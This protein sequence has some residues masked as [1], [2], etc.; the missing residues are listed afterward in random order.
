[1][2][3]WLLRLA[4]LAAAVSCR[5]MLMVSTASARAFERW[6]QSAGSRRAALALAA[7]HRARAAN[8]WRTAFEQAPLGMAKISLEGRVQEANGAWHALLGEPQRGIAG[9]RLSAFVYPED[10][11][12]LSGGANPA[13]PGNPASPA[14]LAK[15]MA[16]AE[17][18]LVC[19]GGR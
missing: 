11:P 13:S 5:A 10:L 16:K 7:A 14:N 9:R 15:G 8:R 4:L 17:V 1:M 18:R 12:I 2:A 6:S 3:T 19:A